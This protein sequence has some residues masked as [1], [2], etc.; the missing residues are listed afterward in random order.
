MIQTHADRRLAENLGTLLTVLAANVRSPDG[1]EMTREANL[2]GIVK[3]LFPGWAAAQATP[4]L[5]PALS[6]GGLATVGGGVIGL[7]RIWDA[8][9]RIATKDENVGKPLTYEDVRREGPR[10]DDKW[11]DRD[12]PTDVGEVPPSFY[13]ETPDYEPWYLEQQRAHRDAYRSNVSGIPMG[14]QLPDYIFRSRSQPTYPVAPSN[15]FD[16]YDAE[17]SSVPLRSSSTEGERT[18]TAQGRGDYTTGR[19]DVQDVRGHPLGWLVEGPGD[20]ESAASKGAAEGWYSPASPDAPFLDPSFGRSTAAEWAP[21]GTPLETSIRR[22]QA[23]M[24]ST[25]E[26]MGTAMNWRVGQ[27]LT[28]LNGGM[29][30]RDQASELIWQQVDM[31]EAMGVPR[32]HAEGALRDVLESVRAGRAGGLPSDMVGTELP[33]R[34]EASWDVNLPRSNALRDQML[35]NIADQGDRLRSMTP[36]FGSPLRAYMSG[37][38]VAGGIY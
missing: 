33:G 6:L 14:Q 34:E 30:D 35:Q 12:R 11:W 20:A 25:R 27:I 5:L 15:A 16:T 19:R 36:G 7:R 2:G 1:G 24:G 38:D 3:R 23:M 37:E 4:W 28:W 13:L 17:T 29:I 21:G 8:I 31:M 26:R 18:V 32:E 22:Q 9:K 10:S